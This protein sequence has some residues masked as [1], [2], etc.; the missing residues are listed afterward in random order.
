MKQGASFLAAAVVLL[1]VAAGVIVGGC[2]AAQPPVPAAPPQGQQPI[3]E[4]L[5]NCTNPHFAIFVADSGATSMLSYDI[6][7]LS[8]TTNLAPLSDITGANTKLNAPYGVAVD[9]DVDEYVANHGASLI[10]AYGWYDTGNVSPQGNITGPAVTNLNTPWNA[11][12]DY[13]ADTVYA[14]NS[15]KSITVY[16]E[17]VFPTPRPTQD[18]SGANTQLNDGRGIAVDNSGGTYNEDV[19]VT[20]KSGNS[21]LM[22]AK[23]A[24][25]N[26]FPIHVL[27]GANTKLSS[28]QGVAVDGSGNVYVANQ[29]ANQVLAFSA[30]PSGNQSPLRSIQGANTGLLHPTGITVGTPDGF[31]FELIVTNQGSPPSITIYH[32]NDNGNVAPIATIKGAA[33]GLVT[34][35]FL[36]YYHI[37][38]PMM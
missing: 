4:P 14:L 12:M 21:V 7:G 31:N 26:V 3:M 24:T 1:L 33:T 10:T 8:G 9:D 2:S 27:S 17:G 18:I 28:P 11:A 34:P 6:T 19:Y 25:G 5:R 29:G 16:P 38:N 36:Q 13:T 23:G 22:F 30:A 32:L 20:N 37:C 15:N 35:Q